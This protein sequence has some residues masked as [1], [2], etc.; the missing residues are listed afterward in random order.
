MEVIGLNCPAEVSFMDAA[1]RS[2][3]LMRPP[4]PTFRGPG[5]RRGARSDG[6]AQSAGRP[7]STRTRAGAPAAGSCPQSGPAQTR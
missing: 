4:P 7:A 6:L 2:R 5:H 3:L 1:H